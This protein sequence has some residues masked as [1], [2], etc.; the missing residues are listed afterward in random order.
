MSLKRGGQ[1]VRNSQRAWWPLFFSLKLE[2]RP[3]AGPM[4]VGVN[5]GV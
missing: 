1:G 4:S 5:E 3:F 2:M